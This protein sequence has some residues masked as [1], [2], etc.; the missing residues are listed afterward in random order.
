MKEFTYLGYIMKCN[1][2]D[3]GQIKKLEGKVKSVV[4]RIWSI[5]ERK[6]KEDWD[7]RMRLFDALIELVMMEPK[8][9]DGKK[10]KN[11]KEYKGNILNGC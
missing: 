4:G 2:S 9:G 5:G 7:K 10:G 1:N 6:F 8:F 3:E 11:W